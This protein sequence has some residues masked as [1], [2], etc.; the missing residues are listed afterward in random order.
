MLRVKARLDAAHVVLDG[1]KPVSVVFQLEPM[2]GPWEMR[3][4][5]KRV[6]GWVGW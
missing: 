2:L 6:D 1:G 3:D 5:A 4:E